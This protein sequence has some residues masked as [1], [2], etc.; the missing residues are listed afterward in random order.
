MEIQVIIRNTSPI[1]SAAP[2]ASSISLDGVFKP[3]GEGFPLTRARTMTVLAAQVDGALKPVELPVVPGNTMRNLLRRTM[4]KEVIEPTLRGTT[5]LGIGAYAAAYAGNAS[6][7]PDGK[8]STLDEIVEMRAH[9]FI[10]L[11]G[12]GPRMLEGRLM[13]DTMY[14]IHSNAT[15]VIGEGFE[16]QIFN[17]KLTDFIWTRRVDPI[18][19]LRDEED[20]SIIEGGAAAANDWIGGLMASTKAKAAQRKK[21]DEEVTEVSEV[22]DPRGLTAFN[23]HEV[24]IPGVNWLWRIKADAPND[25][26]I[27]LILDALS[28]MPKYQI[29]GGHAKGY[30]EFIIE[31]ITLDGQKVWF[32]GHLDGEKVSEYLDALAEAMDSM[33]GEAFERFA[34]SSKGA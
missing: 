8:P 34:A 28:K 10:G 25:A 21:K 27:G 12:G 30:G 16:S 15:R 3:A 2:G 19:R 31:S 6:G 17:G 13:I 18:T 7:N 14:P 1:F 22:K 33:S 5:K 32:D 4:L 26:Q 29:A 20:A 11:F 9:P 24:V 23:A